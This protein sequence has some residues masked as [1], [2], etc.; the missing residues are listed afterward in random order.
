M[1]QRDFLIFKESDADI[2]CIQE[3]KLQQ[4]Q[5]D[6]ELDGY[7]QYWNYAEKKGYSGTAL[8][9]KQEPLS[10]TYGIGIEQHDKE[11]RVI[12]AEFDNFYCVTC[13]TPNSQNEL[14]RL[15]YRME[16]EDA[17]RAYLLEL[18]SKKPVIMCGDLNVAPKIDL[19]I[20][21]QTE[22]CRLYRRGKRKNDRSPRKR[23]YRYIPIFQSRQGGRLF[24]VVV[25]L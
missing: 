22:K 8:F 11:G 16:W 14:K 13:Y 23:F 9:T 19:K 4:G 24:M 7:Y 15:E 21:K 6:L 1:L 17:F 2:F 12:T 3:T 20:Q 25:P 5:I 18:N 10:V